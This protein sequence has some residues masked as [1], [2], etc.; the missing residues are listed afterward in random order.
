M[1]SALRD[2][3]ETL[4]A[5]RISKMVLATNGVVLADCNASSDYVRFLAPSQSWELSFDDIYA[6][7]WKHP[8]DYP[9]ELRH[10]SRK[11][12]EV[13]VPSC[14]PTDLLLGA[15]VLNG[16]VKS[17]LQALGFPLAITIDPDLFFR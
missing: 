5:M 15:Y 17:R 6:R 1:M 11:C 12:A 10:K 9:T 13:L 16:K 14:V 8:D 7:N 4:C 2:Q 3:A